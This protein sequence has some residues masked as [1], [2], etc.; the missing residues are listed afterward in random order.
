MS[1]R[2]SLSL[3]LGNQLSKLL[4]MVLNGL[5]VLQELLSQLF[6]PAISCQ[7]LER[8]RSRFFKFGRIKQHICVGNCQ[9]V[10][11]AIHRLGR[12]AQIPEDTF[13]TSAQ[14]RSTSVVSLIGFLFLAILRL[15]MPRRPAVHKAG[16]PDRL[17][18]T[19]IHVK[20]TPGWPMPDMEIR[21]EEG[22]T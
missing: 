5:D 16:L 11:R 15:P 9:H 17:Q 21:Q 10:I 6:T 20:Y 1:D 13:G 2:V 22:C 4:L 18:L 19:Q 12:L 3:L 7:S 8:S 14:I